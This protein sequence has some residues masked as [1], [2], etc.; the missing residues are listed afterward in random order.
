[1]ML[2]KTRMSLSSKMTT[3]MKRCQHQEQAKHGGDENEA[4]RS[5]RSRS[6]G[7]QSVTAEKKDG[8]YT[9]HNK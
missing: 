9:S 3:V 2:M 1:M 5:R 4:K 8:G 6:R 7:T